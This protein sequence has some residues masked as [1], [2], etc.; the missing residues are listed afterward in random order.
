MGLSR[1]MKGSLQTW[2]YDVAKDKGNYAAEFII[3]EPA[4]NASKILN[5]YKNIE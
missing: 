4:R 2:Q 1:A 3:S 5:L